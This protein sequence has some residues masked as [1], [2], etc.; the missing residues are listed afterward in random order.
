M[1]FHPYLPNHLIILSKNSF[2]AGTHWE[3]MLPEEVKRGCEE[4]G[5]TNEYR[6]KAK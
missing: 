1:L 6:N 2:P 3:R 4:E 5:W